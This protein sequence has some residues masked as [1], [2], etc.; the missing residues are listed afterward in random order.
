LWLIESDVFQ[1]P[2]LHKH[3]Y[4][5]GKQSDEKKLYLPDL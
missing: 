4:V 5:S 1:M 3:F 2:Q